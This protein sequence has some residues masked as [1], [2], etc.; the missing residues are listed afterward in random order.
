MGLL[1]GIGNAAGWAGRR[2]AMRSKWLARR[3]WL[4]AVAEGAMVSRRHWMRLEPAERRRLLSLAKKSKGRP[5]THL[6][7]SERREA[8]QLL[9]K[10][11]HIELAG[12]IATIALPFK[13]LSKLATRF[14]KGRHER[15]HRELGIEPP[16]APQGKNGAQPAQEQEKAGSRA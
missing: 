16:S 8:H 5:S 1:R 6:S 4:I 15:A 12:N 9:D 11:G 13:P 10:L 7:S 2:I 14:V 3:L